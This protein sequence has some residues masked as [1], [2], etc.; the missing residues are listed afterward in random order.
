MR[1]AVYALKNLG[2]RLAD[3]IATS[4]PFAMRPGAIDLAVCPHCGGQLRG[5]ASVTRRDVIQRILAHPSGVRL[6][7]TLHPTTELE[8]GARA[9]R[10]RYI[11]RCSR[12]QAACTADAR[13]RLRCFAARLGRRI[14]R[15]G[16]EE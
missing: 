10:V 5:N 1:S 13:A 12:W 2:G 9:A 8:S 16:V 4:I 3:C 11:L 6:Q 14:S 15:R 7:R